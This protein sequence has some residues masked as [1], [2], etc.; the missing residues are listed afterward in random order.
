MILY[1]LI[2]FHETC[3]W[4]NGSLEFEQVTPK[5]LLERVSLATRWGQFCSNKI[6]RDERSRYA[7]DRP[8]QAA[9]NNL[10]DT[11]RDKGN[12]AQENQQ[13]VTNRPAIAFLPVPQPSTTKSSS[14]FLVAEASSRW[15]NAVGSI[16][17]PTRLIY[18]F[19][20]IIHL[21]AAVTAA[22]ARSNGAQ[23]PPSIHLSSPFRFSRILPAARRA[24]NRR[25]G[26][27]RLHASALPCK[28]TPWAKQASQQIVKPPIRPRYRAETQPSSVYK[29][30]GCF[31]TC[32]THLGS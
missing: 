24:A 18:C 1:P 14:L 11:Y 23:T 19:I 2:Q 12:P 6:V 29:Y 15:S 22:A 17:Q 28:S 27:F 25:S 32:G 4:K 30:T 7:D 3:G 5:V 21:F 16:L 13:R 20:T 9:R 10:E 31:E 8:P 26:W